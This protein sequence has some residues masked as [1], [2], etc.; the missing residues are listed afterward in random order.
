[1]RAP[2]RSSGRDSVEQRLMCAPF[3]GGFGETDLEGLPEP[4]QRYLRAAIRPEGVVARSVSLRMHG[5]IK[6]G[7]WLPFRA[8]QML[9]PHRG[10][11]WS[12]RVA[13]LISGSD[14][15]VDGAGAMRWTLGG[16]VTVARGE[17]PDVS[18]SAAGRAAAEAIWVPTALLPRCGVRWDSQGPESATLYYELDGND[19]SVTYK[20]DR[21]GRI[22]SLVSDRWGDPDGTGR[23]GWHRFG[24][25][26][27]SHRMFGDVLIPETGRV[28]W[29][30]GTERWPEGAFF[31]FT[32]TRAQPCAAA[33]GRSR[34][35]PRSGPAS[36]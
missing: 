11:V 8:R 22:T 2:V 19:V 24:G 14:R 5:R 27:H 17:G 12:A 3:P 20:L 18:R 21:Q 34:P 10:F 31:E 1:V 25:E 36:G 29:H 26:I 7:R 28:G 6:V 35:A 23:W 33:L 30:F 13:G 15:Y 9:A 16:L 32:I 4:A